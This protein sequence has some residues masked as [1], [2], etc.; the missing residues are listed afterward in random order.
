MKKTITISLML[1]LAVSA[2]AQKEVKLTINHMLGD[3]PFAKNT[4]ASNNLGHS[5]KLQRLEYYISEIS[6]EHD[7]GIITPITDLYILAKANQVDTISLGLLDVTTIE[8]ISFHIGV[9]PGVNN[10]DPSLWSP[11]HP[12]SPKSPS[13]HWGWSSGYRFVAL[14]GK[15]GTNFSQ[16][17]QIHALGNRNYFEQ[18]IPIEGTDVN[19]TLVLT[20]N[21]DY[22]QALLGMEISSG[23]I[24]HSEYDEAA[25]CIRL[26]QT[27]VFT[28]QS[29]QGNTLNVDD[30]SVENAFD[31]FPNPSEGT[32]N[33][34]IGDSRFANAQIRVTNM[35]GAV[36]EEINL[37]N[38]IHQLS[39]TEQGVYFLTITK[40]GLSSTEKIIIQ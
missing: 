11:M 24:E 33:L 22:T 34:H 32:I 37:V 18:N 20:L 5:F 2:F 25:E 26:F 9:D 15:S 3:N 23:L 16:D 8:S 19:G 27:R 31:V 4:E 38:T 35:L 29:G 17:F 10:G 39:L 12:L 21:A 1:L 36:V 30:T 6:V 7:G 13:M 40:D 28:N 14:E